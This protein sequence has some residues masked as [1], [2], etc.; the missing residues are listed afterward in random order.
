MDPVDQRSLELSWLKQAS[1]SVDFMD[2]VLTVKTFRLA[3]AHS[4][5]DTKRQQLDM[6]N[7]KRLES[8]IG[9]H[10]EFKIVA[11]HD[12]IVC[13]QTQSLHRRIS[14]I[15][16]ITKL[17]S[18]YCSLLSNSKS[19]NTLGIHIYCLKI[20]IVMAIGLRRLMETSINDL[21][22]SKVVL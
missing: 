5:S 10:P 18:S 6:D 2:T 9:S 20:V 11:Q 19:T 1:C 7:L 12:V 14:L 8:F 3:D 13:E 17:I 16:T 15:E 22:T 4:Y 21:N